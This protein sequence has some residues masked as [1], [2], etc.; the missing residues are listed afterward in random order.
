MT[1]VKTRTGDQFSLEIKMETRMAPVG[2][3]LVVQRS[4]YIDAEKC[5]GER[6]REEQRR[7]AGEEEKDSKRR[8]GI[9]K[10]EKMYESG[11]VQF[12]C[13]SDCAD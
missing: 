5:K 13:S 8:G 9:R 12:A 2:D 6:V 11:Y 3:V 7:R 4:K 1:A 10:G